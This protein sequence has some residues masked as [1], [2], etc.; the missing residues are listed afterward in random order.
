MIAV[1]RFVWVFLVLASCASTSQLR[2]PAVD[3][4][5]V[6]C[7]LIWANLEST[8]SQQILLSL[9]KL[10]ENQCDAEVVLLGDQVRRHYRDK[11]YFLGKESAEFIGTDGSTTD[12]VLEGYERSYLSTL[13]AMSEV[14]RKRF[15]KAQ[16]ELRRVY[17]EQKALIYNESEDPVTIAVQAVLWENTGDPAE[18][19]VHWKRLSENR[20]ADATSRLFALDR[21]DKI[22]RRDPLRPWEI[23]SLGVFP[24]INWEFSLANLGSS[25]YRLKPASRF[26][27]S[28]SEGQ[29]GLLVSA[30]PW[31]QELEKR[32]SMERHPLTFAKTVTRG[33]IGLSVG[34]V[35]GTL[36]VGVAVL[37]C[38]AAKDSQ[39]ACE[40]AI[41]LGMEM[42]Q[43]GFTLT[44]NYLTPDLRKWPNLP[45]GFFFHETGAKSST[46]VSTEADRGTLRLL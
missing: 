27:S 23:Y 20:R 5:S 1:M 12:Y 15:A 44:E 22:D 30:E 39:Q 40:A 46:C 7:S 33:A 21:I 25:Y 18:A 38:Y 43:A 41:R 35:T 32:Y 16:V 8:K 13:M 2:V 9:T 45:G 24:E 17:E 14:R 19:R 31:F 10:Y 37:G 11:V 36:G 28:C 29:E 34:A 6:Q 4:T 3:S 42:A 26:P